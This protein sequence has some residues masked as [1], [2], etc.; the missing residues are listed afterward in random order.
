MEKHVKQSRY[1]CQNDGCSLIDVKYD[2]R[3][4]LFYDHHI[5][6][7]IRAPRLIPA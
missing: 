5:D 6:A 7:R 2:E 4:D 3:T 1:V